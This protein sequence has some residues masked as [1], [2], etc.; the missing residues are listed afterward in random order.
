MEGS[1]G[2]VGFAEK[3]FADRGGRAVDVLPVLS[4]VNA[5]VNGMG[6]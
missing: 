1:T 5:D 2:F 4:T 6:C 3:Y